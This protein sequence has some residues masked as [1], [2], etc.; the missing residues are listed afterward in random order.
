MKSIQAY[1]FIVQCS[2]LL[3]QVMILFVTFMINKRLQRKNAIMD[4]DR[5]YFDMTKM[6]IENDSLHSFYRVGDEKEKESWDAMSPEEKRIWIFHE[7]NYFH[8]AVVYN[9]AYVY[10]VIPKGHWLLYEKWLR[11]LIQSSDIF[12][13]VHERNKGMFEEYFAKRVDEIMKEA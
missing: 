6:M 3:A 4:C 7:L 2:I 13:K 1:G 8:F 11:V 9:S 5:L 10:K 12:K